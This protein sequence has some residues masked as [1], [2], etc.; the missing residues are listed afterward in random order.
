MELLAAG[1]NDFRECLA[2]GVNV[3]ASWIPSS[4]MMKTAA[5]RGFTVLLDST[6]RMHTVGDN[7]EGQL[8][9]GSIGAEN[10]MVLRRVG[11]LD[12]VVYIAAGSQHGAAIT[13]HGKLYTWGRNRHGM[14]C[15]CASKRHVL[16][17]TQTLNVKTVWRLW[18]R[19]LSFGA[20]TYEAH[21]IDRNKEERS[22]WE[23]RKAVFT[24]RGEKSFVKNAGWRIAFVACGVD[25]TVA[26]TRDGAVFTFG[27]D[28]PPQLV[29]FPGACVRRIVVC[30]AGADHTMLV[31]DKGSLFGMGRSY[32]GALGLGD[33]LSS[34]R[35]MQLD[36]A[37]F[38][39]RAVVAAACGLAH[40]LLLTADGVAYSMGSPRLGAT[41]R[42][43]IH[44]TTYTI[45]CPVVG[46]ADVVV[47]IAAGRS[48][49]FLLTAHGSVFGCGTGAGI[50]AAG[51][52]GIPQQLPLSTSVRSLGGGC[53]ANHRIFIA[54]T[55]PAE[56][57]FE[58]PASCAW[59]RRRVLLM[60]LLST[61]T[62]R[63][64]GAPP[65]PV[66]TAD[67]VLLRMAALPADLW[68]AI[69]QYL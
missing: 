34:K 4:A 42:G 21:A 40:T 43:H 54:G 51:A 9:R 24:E 56:P 49:S 59:L 6:A 55:P 13:E 23:K 29:T 2:D 17:P 48:H 12:N 65:P 27:N 57:G 25:H 28:M 63:V 26:V 30:A 37:H 33:T 68:G 22:E 61:R 32:L 36:A 47:R 66:E 50:P 15:P 8:G 31:S 5:G 41:G 35:P 67:K 20:F 3:S 69:F 19:C 39:D 14:C 52:Q 10:A 60:S 62:E 38:E 11:S 53:A 46:V 58:G 1:R 7:G 44:Y 45:P 16:V 64:E 18:T